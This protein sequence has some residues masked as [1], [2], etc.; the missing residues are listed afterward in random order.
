PFHLN[1]L[2]ARDVAK[3]G[4][5]FTL[6]TARAMVSASGAAATAVGVRSGCAAA[7]GMEVN[8]ASERAHTMSH[9]VR[10][11]PECT[12]EFLLDI[13]RFELGATVQVHGETGGD[14]ERLDDE[15]RK[16]VADGYRDRE[17]RP[18]LPREELLD[19]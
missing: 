10:L 3:L 4:S 8:G 17:E 11:V 19:V 6:A 1:V 12:A 16:R 9:A 14:I 15:H 7:I 13:P 18:R 2:I 5:A